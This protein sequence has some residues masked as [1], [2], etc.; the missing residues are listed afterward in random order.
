MNARHKTY[1]LVQKKIKQLKSLS[2]TKETIFYS[3]AGRVC[4]A[5]QTN[6]ATKIIDCHI[7]TAF[8]RLIITQQSFKIGRVGNFTRRVIEN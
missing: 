7:Q 5:R 4:L 6:G 3:L 2:F 8:T 1:I